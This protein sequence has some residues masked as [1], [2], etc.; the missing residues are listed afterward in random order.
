MYN[1]QE[2]MMISQEW[3]ELKK[4]TIKYST[5]IKY[6]RTVE[7]QLFPFYQTMN[8][9]DL[10]E[11]AIMTFFRNRYCEKHYSVSTIHT[12]RF[13]LHSILNYA[14]HRYGY[15]HID[16]RYIKL[17]KPRTHP[18]VLSLQQESQ[19]RKYCFKERNTVSSAIMLGLYAGLRIGEICALQWQDLDLEQGIIT[20]NKTVQRIENQNAADTKTSLMIF[21]PKTDASKRLVPIPDFLKEY[22]IHYYNEISLIYNKERYVI[23]N[24]FTPT[25]PRTVQYRFQKVCLKNDFKAN[26]HALR[27]TYATRCVEIGVEI[28][29]LS[30]ILG[31]SNVSITLNRYVHSSLKFKQDQINKIQQSYFFVE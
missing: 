11:Q 18:Q 2:M 1:K 12:I 13:L 25:D 24:L 31:H 10:D 16:F 22:F 26:F 15:R 7:L 9:K 23:S 17:P 20:I 27:H 8:A 19:L 5:Y 4:L 14:E 6:K 29:S 3:L 28:K 21:E 30:E